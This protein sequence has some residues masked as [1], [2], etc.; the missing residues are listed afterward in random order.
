MSFSWEWTPMVAPGA[1]EW[2]TRRTGWRSKGPC[3]RCRGCRGQAPTGQKE[4]R[5]LRAFWAEWLPSGGGQSQT[6]VSGVRMSRCRKPRRSRWQLRGAR[7]A[8]GPRRALLEVYWQDIAVTC[9]W[10]C[11][12]RRSA[13]RVTRWRGAATWRRFATRI[14]QVR[15]RLKGF[16][17]FSE[18]AYGDWALWRPAARV[19]K[20]A[21]CW[22]TEWEAIVRFSGALLRSLWEVGASQLQGRTKSA[23]LRRP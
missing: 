4:P 19:W 18:T 14:V 10:R 2:G 1:A 23:P 21:K 3:A 16:L 8:V 7:G 6:R 12:V 17:P 22:Q 5:R 9:V 13:V 20:G 15:C 11:P